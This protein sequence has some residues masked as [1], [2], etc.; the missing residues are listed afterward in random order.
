M[1]NSP[2]CQPQSPIA[3]QRVWLRYPSRRAVS[4]RLSETAGAPFWPAQACD[5]SCGGVKLLSVEKLQRGT[6]LIICLKGLESPVTAQ[7]RYAIPSPEGKWLAG[8][9]FQ[10]ELSEQELQNWLQE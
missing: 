4:C 5:V 3:D 10:D 1:S 6:L 7:V 2:P 9:A 8:C